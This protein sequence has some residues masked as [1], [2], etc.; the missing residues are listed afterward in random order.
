VAKKEQQFKTYKTHVDS[1]KATFDALNHLMQCFLNYKTKRFAA[2]K[3][4]NI[5]KVDTKKADA[6]R[7]TQTF[8]NDKGQRK[9]TFDARYSRTMEKSLFAFTSSRKACQTDAIFLK[10]GKLERLKDKYTKAKNKYRNYK[11]HSSH[12]WQGVKE[13]RNRMNFFH[14]K[15]QQT[16]STIQ[17]LQ[18][19]INN[20]S[21]DN[22]VFGSKA[23]W[24]K[25]NTFIHN[26][27]ASKEKKEKLKQ[28]WSM[29]GSEIEC[30][31]HKGEEYGNNN[32]RL[33]KC[34]NVD[35]DALRLKN[36]QIE[37]TNKNKKKGKKQKNKNQK[38]KKIAYPFDVEIKVPP[39]LQQHYGKFITLHN[40]KFY[41]GKEE[42]LDNVE[43]CEQ[44]QTDLRDYT[45]EKNRYN[46]A[47]KKLKK[48]LKV[49]DNDDDVK[50]IHHQIKTIEARIE[51][52][53][54]TKPLADTYGCRAFSLL[55]NKNVDDRL[56]VHVSV[57]QREHDLITHDKNGVIGI[58]INYDNI[59]IADINKVGQLLS[60]HVY[61]YN[62]GQTHSSIYREHHI[63][64]AVN[65]IIEKAKA[66]KKDIVIE[67]LDFIKTKIKQ[68]KGINPK[69][70]YKT[71]SFP[72]AKVINKFL[73][74]G[75]LHGVK[76]HQ[77][78]P[79]Y[80][81]L[82]GKI[83]YTKAYGLST[84]QAAA[85][86]MARRY[87]GLKEKIPPRLVFNHRGVSCSVSL[88][89]DKVHTHVR[90]KQH[91]HYIVNNELN[92]QSLYQWFKKIVLAYQQ[93]PLTKF[94]RS[95]RSWERSPSI[96]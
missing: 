91:S 40:V 78:N 54:E 9:D 70:N 49:I 26:P 73:T 19:M 68:D 62:F 13:R 48:Q 65:A 58:D 20:D 89:E 52:N 44:F 11:H 56:S 45:N 18:Q 14:R 23:L 36:K 74:E 95:N 85:Y 33:K 29:R 76:V 72:Y 87:Y 39:V 3:K 63:H 1:D 34:A 22:I 27:E 5:T 77:K 92:I 79:A 41:Y 25:Y 81:S 17:S 93:F 55:I 31:G 90:K 4:D 51:K 15:I 64:K 66:L 83:C 94:D 50:L 42:L 46:N 84:H 37:E 6:F 86:V 38:Q 96:A 28:Q 43:A 2:I 57:E 35:Y 71:H 88:P 47:I 30:Y 16:Q 7:Q 67:D 82:L 61:R 75:F 80:S 21:K 24:D 8:I 69:H 12:D 53:E 60:S 10:E 32:I 59:A